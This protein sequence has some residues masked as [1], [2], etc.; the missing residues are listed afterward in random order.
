MKKYFLITILLLLTLNIVSAGSYTYSEYW[1]E[2]DDK[3]HITHNYKYELHCDKDNEKR[4]P[5]S[6]Y[7]YGWSYRNIHKTYQRD[8][9]IRYYKKPRR[10]KHY[11]TRY[12]RKPF[13]YQEYDSKPSYYYKYNS[14]LREHEL[15]KCY[16]SPPHGKLFYSKC[17]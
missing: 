6:H 1:D 16:H 10:Y 3:V 14:Y 9:K 7:R 11:K 2:N 13:Y 5:I 8:Y 17:P 12:H 15:K 4:Y